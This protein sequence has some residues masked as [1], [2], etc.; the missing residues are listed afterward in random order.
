MDGTRTFFVPSSICGSASDISDSEDDL[1]KRISPMASQKI[2]L[3]VSTIAFQFLPLGH[4]LNHDHQMVWFNWHIPFDDAKTKQNPSLLILMSLSRSSM[5]YSLA[6]CVSALD[7]THYA[8]SAPLFSSHVF[9][10]LSI[11]LFI[12]EHLVFLIHQGL[13]SDLC[14]AIK[15]FS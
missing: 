6:H 12:F 14:L 15:R 10:P 1:G 11:W 5:N 2:I 4:L 3:L 13:K 9:C 7:L 8:F